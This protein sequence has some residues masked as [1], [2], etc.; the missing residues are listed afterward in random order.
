V[1]ARLSSAPPTGEIAQSLAVL[2]Q[3]AERKLW[4]EAMTGGGKGPYGRHQLL[5]ENTLTV[6]LPVMAKLSVRNLALL[7]RIWSI[8]LLANLAGTLFAALFCTFTPV[9]TSE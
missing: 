4:T 7:A 1:I 3:S 8:V 9:L 5:T 2:E 6:V